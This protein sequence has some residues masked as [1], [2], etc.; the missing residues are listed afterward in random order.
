MRLR[1][2]G[3]ADIAAH[4]AAEDAEIIRWLTG[5]QGT[6]ESTRR[7]FAALAA[8]AERGQGKRGFGVVVDGRLGGYVDCDPDNSDG[9]EPGELGI[10]NISYT[11]HAW[12]RRRGVATRAVALI[13]DYIGVH[14]IGDRAALRI[15]PDNVASLG[16]AERAGFRFDR[17][18]L[19]ATDTHPDGTPR[20]MRLY[21]LDI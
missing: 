21:L 3:E 4:N 10:V 18:F 5:E 20:R 14:R 13:C 15:E 19:S 1:A 16:V 8:N 7:H 6:T 2:L 17:D 12:A 11:T 9:L